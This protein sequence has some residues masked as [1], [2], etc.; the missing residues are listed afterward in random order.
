MSS[1]PR[2]AH[3]QPPLKKA[4]STAGPML[5]PSPTSLACASDDSP[6]GAPGTYDIVQRSPSVF[7]GGAL[8]AFDALYQELPGST[9]IFDR[10][11]GVE[12]GLPMLTHVNRSYRLPDKKQINIPWFN[13]AGA[14]NSICHDLNERH[15][16]VVVNKYTRSVCK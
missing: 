7:S 5:S 16:S 2:G 9:S 15:Q 8:D 4:R 10:F 11:V 1:T 6:P 3:E 14:P 12:S 13:A